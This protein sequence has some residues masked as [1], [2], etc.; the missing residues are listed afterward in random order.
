MHDFDDDFGQ[1][2]TGDRRKFPDAY[3]LLREGRKAPAAR[4]VGESRGNAVV[5]LEQFIATCPDVD[6]YKFEKMTVFDHDGT[7]PRNVVV[8]AIVECAGS[9]IMVNAHEDACE[10]FW[11]TCVFNHVAPKFGFE[12]H[13]VTPTA[14]ECSSPRFATLLS[15]A[16]HQD[17]DLQKMHIDRIALVFKHSRRPTL[18]NIHLALGGASRGQKLALAAVA[19]G[20]VRLLPHSDLNPAVR[21]APGPMLESAG[22]PDGGAAGSPPP[23]DQGLAA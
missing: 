16:N 14:I 6:D 3:F 19:Q 10:A 21:V 7:R 1:P 2:G 15:V 5:L 17:I 8:H 4:K 22:F 12:S 20:Y 13:V 23:A 9:T 18:G 11:A